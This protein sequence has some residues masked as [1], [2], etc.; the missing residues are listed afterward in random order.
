MGG[1]DT[2]AAVRGFDADTGGVCCGT[3]GLEASASPGNAVCSGV[4]DTSLLAPDPRYSADRFSGGR[5]RD[6]RHNRISPGWPLLYWVVETPC[7]IGTRKWKHVCIQ[8]TGWC[9]SKA[10]ARERSR[11]LGEIPVRTITAASL[12]RQTSRASST[13][14]IEVRRRPERLRGVRN[15]HAYRAVCGCGRIVGP[16]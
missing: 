4:A 14:T 1:A 15:C 7:K 12:P 9:G 8:P 2:K 13:T 6:G 3:P 5:M 10:H 16:Q 11:R